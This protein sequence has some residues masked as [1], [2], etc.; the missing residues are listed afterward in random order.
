MLCSMLLLPCLRRAGPGAGLLGHPVPSVHS[1]HRCSIIPGK[2]ELLLW[3]VNVLFSETGILCS[4][5][6]A[7]SATQ[8]LSELSLPFCGE[9]IFL[10]L[11]GN[12]GTR[13][14]WIPL[15]IKKELSCCLFP[16]SPGSLLQ[17]QGGMS[18]HLFCSFQGAEQMFSVWCRLCA[19]SRC[20]KSWHLLNRNLEMISSS[21]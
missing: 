1:C 19:H 8:G 6:L 14:L 12:K 13:L 15:P 21:L 9:G 4:S 7:R 10:N 5:S 18:C 3:H 11:Y 20:S 16:S 2:V 17:A